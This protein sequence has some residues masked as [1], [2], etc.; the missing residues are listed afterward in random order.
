MRRGNREDLLRKGG[1]CI[2]RYYYD[3]DYPFA[4]YIANLGMYKAGRLVGEWVKFP[5]TA[6]EMRQTLKNIGIG[7]KHNR[8]QAYENWL[9]FDDVSN[10]EVLKASALKYK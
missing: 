2:S 6:E 7:K 9:V 4:V 5:T 10:L 8:D 1:I 3:S